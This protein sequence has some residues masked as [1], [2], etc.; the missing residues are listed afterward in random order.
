MDGALN[1]NGEINR[2]MTKKQRIADYKYNI[3][4]GSKELG[5]WFICH[6][7]PIPY[8]GFEYRNMFNTYPELE[9]VFPENFNNQDT[10]SGYTFNSELNL[11]MFLFKNE[12]DALRETVLL[13]AIELAK[14]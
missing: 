1:L 13:L 5:S 7:F 8:K 3:E 14:D 11:G 12:A 6:N 4:K 2:I 10:L 9:L